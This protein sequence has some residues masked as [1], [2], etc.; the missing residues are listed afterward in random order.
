MQKKCQSEFSVSFDNEPENVIHSSKKIET[1]A[2]HFEIKLPIRVEIPKTITNESTRTQM[3]DENEKIKKYENKAKLKSPV[4]INHPKIIQKKSLEPILNKPIIPKHVDSNLVKL[5][6]SAKLA[7]QLFLQTSECPQDENAFQ[8]IKEYSKNIILSEKDS[9]FPIE[10]LLSPKNGKLPYFC[11]YNFFYEHWYIHSPI[12]YRSTDRKV[13]FGAP[14]ER[15][16]C[17]EFSRSTEVNEQN[18]FYLSKGCS[19]NVSY[20]KNSNRAVTV[21]DMVF[22]PIE[23]ANKVLLAGFV[24]FKKNK[25]NFIG[26]GYVYLP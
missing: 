9:N 26:L 6:R 18:V 2:S 20:R 10:S 8:L 7:R 19:G 16:D 4:F 11:G 1:N 12:F 5:A 3:N 14:L 15:N 25:T 24:E 13:I 17:F 23:G 21:S 22:V